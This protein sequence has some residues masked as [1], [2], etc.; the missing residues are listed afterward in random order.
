MIINLFAQSGNYVLAIKSSGFNT[1]YKRLSHKWA[2]KGW[3]ILSMSE[4][5]L[6]E[7]HQGCKLLCSPSTYSLLITVYVNHRYNW[8]HCSQLLIILFFFSLCW[9]FIYISW[10]LQDGGCW[11]SSVVESSP[12]DLRFNPL[13]RHPV[14]C[15]GE[16]FTYI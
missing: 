3:L 6:R 10:W 11:D 5:H 9:C 1:A 4:Y 13:T 7:S 15:K 8:F 2:S 14:F 16:F 12:I